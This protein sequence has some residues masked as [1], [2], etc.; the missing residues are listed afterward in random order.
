MEENSEKP[1]AMEA[2]TLQGDFVCTERGN[3]SAAQ[4]FSRLGERLGLQSRGRERWLKGVG[5]GACS[6]FLFVPELQPDAC[7]WSWGW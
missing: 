7:Q 4:S 5:F 1:K 2:G 6:A 3:A